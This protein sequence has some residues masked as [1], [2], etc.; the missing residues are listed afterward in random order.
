MTMATK[1]EIFQRFLPEYLKAKKVHKGGILHTVCDT[2]GLHR[3]AAIRKFRA[4]QM[5][6]PL[7]VAPR[8]GRPRLY[9]PDVI[10]AL[11]FVWDISSSL[12]GELIHPII[13][14][15][16]ALLQ[17]DALWRY[18]AETTRKLKAMSEGSVKAY[19]SSFA[20]VRRKRTSISGTKPSALKEIIPIATGP[21]HDKPPGYGQV[22]TV[23]HCGYSLVGDLVY[24]VTYTDIATHWTILSAQW[25][26]GQRETCKSLT[27]IQQSLP[28]PLR[29]VHP[30]TGSE[31]INWFVKD[32]A[33]V[34][35]VELTRSRPYHKNDNAYVEQKN[36]HVV[37]RFAGYARM[38]RRELVPLLNAFYETLTIYLNHF[39][40]TRKCIEKVRIGSRYQRRYDTA[41]TPY[42]RVIAHSDIQH[43]VKKILKKDHEMLNPL[44]LKQE[45]D[46]LHKQLFKA[47]NDYANHSSSR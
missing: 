11:K 40:P 2:T 43:S 45:L 21:W 10:A 23:V 29:G 30:D 7:R 1:L 32:W 34:N 5:R 9:T 4:L 20:K 26:K 3:K 28:F 6:D 42:S 47:I 27:R 44:I 15:Y 13:S 24:T 17:R 36:G 8:R 38:D 22:D 18:G 41:K 37:R 39:V 14:E 35:R 46:T 16:V 33:D 31:F 12:C 25:N 19:V